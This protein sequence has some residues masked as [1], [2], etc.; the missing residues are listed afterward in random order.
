M[1]SSSEEFF[2]KSIFLKNEKNIENIL[3]AQVRKGVNLVKRVDKKFHMPV[4][5]K[6]YDKNNQ[7]EIDFRNEILIQKTVSHPR[8]QSMRDYF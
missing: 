8:L 2:K 3:I 7:N 1:L 5:V 4:W 6:T